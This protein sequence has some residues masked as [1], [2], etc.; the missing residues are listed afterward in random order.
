[1]S[2]ES[3]CDA[4]WQAMGPDALLHSILSAA[5]E[6]HLE[7][8]P[9]CRAELEHL[10][11]GL[12]GL[13]EELR[14]EEP[15]D[16]WHGMRS[17]V[18]AAVSRPGRLAMLFNRSVHSWRSWWAAPVMA[19][20]LLA[21]L[22]PKPAPPPLVL[23]EEEIPLLTGMEQLTALF[24]PAEWDTTLVQ[25]DSGWP[26]NGHLMDDWDG[27]LVDLEDGTLL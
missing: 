15:A 7:Q 26:D 3:D 9:R 6:H 22:L 16:F 1:M 18:V 24:D 8:C 13:R 4:F 12:R 14:A 20:M 5:Q 11:L 19:A 21:I 17:R 25:A 2:R 27:L 10:Q 23:A